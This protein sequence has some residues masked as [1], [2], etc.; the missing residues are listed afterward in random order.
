MPTRRHILE[1]LSA[2]SILATTGCVA[3]A[4][5]PDPYAAWRDPGQGET[6]PRRFVLAHGLLA[7]NPH[8]RQSWQV[9]LEGSDAMSLF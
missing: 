8:N 7:P 2:T 1:V 5:G 3:A 9:R 4:P 6:D